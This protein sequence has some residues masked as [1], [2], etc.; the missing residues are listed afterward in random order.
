MS[1]PLYVTADWQRFVSEGDPEAAFVVA[2]ADIDRLGLRAAYEQA[3]APAPEPPK[4][5]PVAAN[6]MLRRHEDK[7]L[8]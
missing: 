7:G 4:K 5:A 8:G 1:N 6:K 3:T 2:P